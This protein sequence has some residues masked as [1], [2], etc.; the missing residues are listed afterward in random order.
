MSLSD[1][2]TR[3]AELVW[4]GDNRSA[5]K[6]MV[7]MR[8]QNAETTQ[9]LKHDA[10]E[11]AASFATVREETGALRDSMMGL[12]GM[13]GI[14]GV[15]FGLRDLSDS[16]VNLQRQQAQL[17]SA[18]K[19]TGQQAGDTASRL[20]EMAE[21]LST[22]G[23][24]G[25]T[26]NLQALTQFVGE[27]HS[28]TE[29]QKLLMLA[30]NV[31]RQRGIDMAT[32]Q[33]KLARAYAGSTRGLQ[34]L[35]GPMV[36]STAATVH[37][38]TAHE[39]QIATL[40]DQASMMGKMGG[41]WLRQQEIND[42]ITAQQQDLAE[43]ENKRATG[44]QILAAAMGAFSGATV[45]YA[46][47]TAGAVSNTTNAFQN[48]R[49]HLGMRLNPVLK[50]LSQLLQSVAGWMSKNSALV[51]DTAAAVTG[52]VAAWGALK[53]LRG[54]KTMVL[55]LGKAFKIVTVSESEA[56]V[57][58]EA[59]AASLEIA[60]R[61]LMVSTIAGL[62][63]VG[64]VEM[65]EHWRQVEQVATSVWHGVSTAV[66]DAWGWIKRTVS[67]GVNWIWSKLK[68]L[69]SE[70]EKFI[71][72]TPLGGLIGFGSNLLGGHVGHAF[73]DLAQGVT[74][75]VV[76]S[77][78]SIGVPYRNLWS[79]PSHVTVSPQSQIV[80]RTSDREIGRAT[81]RWALNEAA[82]GPSSISG[83]SLVTGA[84]APAPTLA[85]GG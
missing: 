27:T 46:K 80:L 72:D 2:M 14:G 79:S 36:T 26:E 30:T 21:S 66:S 39:E 59:S 18:L 51:F 41:I 50:E 4:K 60:W 54:I 61:S 57:T 15:A 11:E 64:L 42:H 62:V 77:N 82:R 6:A 81:V 24:F 7:E 56:A 49:E 44:Q 83:G 33:Q 65:I 8:D 71:A 3:V 17:R 34:Q 10:H 19:D 35:L 48:L 40:E 58:G 69:G 85:T 53:I 67:D 75:G 43:L 23:G 45:A 12:L 37:L 22:H 32:V 1:D 13:V 76:Q 29:A 20:N 9:A 16:G 74:G 84:P 52:L 28:A 47:T 38:T 5:I 63:I 25:T 78:G 73:G 68:W 55:D 31:S 70:A